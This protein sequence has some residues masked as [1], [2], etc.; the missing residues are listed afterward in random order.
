MKHPWNKIFYFV[1]SVLIIGLLIRA[2]LLSKDHEVKVVPTLESS[3]AIVLPHHDLILNRFDNFYQNFTQI[4]RDQIKKIIILSPNH[5]QPQTNQMVSDERVKADHGVAIHLPFIAKYFPDAELEGV[6]LSRNIPKSS[7]QKLITQLDQ[8]VEKQSTL[9]LVS[10]DFSHYLDAATANQMDEQTQKLICNSNT[11]EIL[12]LSDDYLDCP[13]C[14]YILLN[15]DFVRQTDKICPE[16][17]FHGNSSQFMPGGDNQHTTSYFVMRWNHQ[18]ELLSAEDLKIE[19]QKK[20]TQIVK[21]LFGGDLSFDR[22]I[23]RMGVQHGLGSILSELKSFFADYDAVIVNLESPITD[24]ESVSMGSAI[25]SRDN[26]IFTSPA[27]TAQVLSDHNLKIV[28]LGNNHILNFGEDGLNRTLDYL[29]A[30]DIAHFGNMDSTSSSYL[31][32]EVDGIRLGLVN[33]NQFSTNSIN[34]SLADIKSVESKSDL[35][36]LYAHWG[37]EYT[38]EANIYIQ[39]LAH[40]FVDQGADL[41]IGSHPHVIQQTEVYQ[42]KKIYY[43]LGNFVFDQ[44][45]SPETKKGLLVEV[46]INA[47]NLDIETNEYY[48]NMKSNGQTVLE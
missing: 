27:E 45:F 15:L 38:P 22:Y 14:V 6:L 5:Y 28:N 11:E 4:E 48:V 7:L 40:R 44:Y 47:A 24:D 23:R 34:Q 10:T 1:V 33:Y 3:Q 18:P 32:K 21:L 20:D 30:A 31:V 36:I 19:T 9:I 43:S 16:M 12:K 26:Y 46:E 17:V 2:N 37:E 41:I 35:T 25:G 39:D 13:A 8:E 42:G 29:S